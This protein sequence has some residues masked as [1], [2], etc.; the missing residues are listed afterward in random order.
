MSVGCSTKTIIWERNDTVK[1]MRNDFR[2]CVNQSGSNAMVDLTTVTYAS[3]NTNC[4]NLSR[5]DSF[6]VYWDMYLQRYHSYSNAW[7]T[8]GTR[9]GYVSFDSPSNRTFTN[10]LKKNAQLRVYVRFRVPF[11]TTRYIG[12]MTSPIWV[13]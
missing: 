13:Y 3:Y 10:I 7:Q 1:C 4:S 8:I 11:P 9:T 6:K 12:S 2:L 5:V